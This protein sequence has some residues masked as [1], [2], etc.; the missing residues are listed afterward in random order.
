MQYEESILI[1]FN[2]VEEVGIFANEKVDVLNINNGSRI[3][4]YATAAERGFK[5]YS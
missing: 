3:T 1:D 4:A 2:Y 5:K